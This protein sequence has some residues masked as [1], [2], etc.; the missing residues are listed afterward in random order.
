MTTVDVSVLVPAAQREAAA[1]A[2]NLIAPGYPYP[3][4]F[5]R[6]VALKSPAPTSQ[7]APTHWRAADQLEQE[8]AVA[9]QYVAVN[10][11]VPAGWVLADGAS[12][13]EQEIVAAMAGVRVWIGNDVGNSVSWARDN[14]NSLTPALM[15]VPDE[16]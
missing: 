5:S 4:G 3:W 6:A 16:V 14:M 15:D 10:G 2:M 13:T 12:M 9:W 7:T 11:A 1:R 8:Y